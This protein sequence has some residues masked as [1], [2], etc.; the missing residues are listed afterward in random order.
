MPWKDFSPKGLKPVT[1]N[2]DGKSPE[3][4]YNLIG[5][6]SEW[7]SS[8]IVSPIAYEPSQI[9]DGNPKSFD[10]TKTYARRGGGWRINVDEVAT[11]DADLGLSARNDVGIR[12]AANVK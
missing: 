12:C 5:N 8:L 2:P 11:Y 9:W 3:G 10:G 6:A 7:T 4:I 1:D